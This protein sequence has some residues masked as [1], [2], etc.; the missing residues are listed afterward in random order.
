[1]MDEIEEKVRKKFRIK[2]YVDNEG[3]VVYVIQRKHWY[4]WS[5]PNGWLSLY[6]RVYVSY[7]RAVNAVKELINKELNRLNIKTKY[8][9]YPF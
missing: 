7:S 2:Q 8:F 4:G 9:Y 5:T 3:D 6:N 1:M